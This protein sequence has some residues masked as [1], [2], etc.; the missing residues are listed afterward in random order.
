MSYISQIQ[1]EF[2]HQ[3]EQL[4]YDALRRQGAFMRPPNLLYVAAPPADAPPN[5]VY[6]P[7]GAPF[8][9]PRVIPPAPQ[10]VP[11]PPPP[12]NRPIGAGPAVIYPPPPAA[13]AQGTNNNNGVPE[14]APN[15]NPPPVVTYPPAAQGGSPTKLFMLPGGDYY[16][17]EPRGGQ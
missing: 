3:V 9:H 6:Q 16:N 1:D 5:N 15:T 7:F 12:P 10:G 8:M 17:Q 11:P 14:G 4:S 13:G 2:M